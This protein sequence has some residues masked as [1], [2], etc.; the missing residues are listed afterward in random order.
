MI[1]ALGRH[2]ATKL[3]IDQVRTTVLQRTRIIPN[4][5]IHPSAYHFK[6]ALKYFAT[7]NPACQ[8]HVA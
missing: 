4:P 3:V 5:S 2:L 8:A 1:N 6:I 7:A